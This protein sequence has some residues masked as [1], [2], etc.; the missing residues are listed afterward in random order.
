M[1]TQEEHLPL[2]PLLVQRADPISLLDLELA[3]QSSL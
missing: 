1:L 2:F 3:I